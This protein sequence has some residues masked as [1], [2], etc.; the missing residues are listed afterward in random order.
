MDAGQGRSE[1]QDGA[2]TAPKDPES[3]V[4]QEFSALPEALKRVLSLENASQR[5]K[6]KFERRQAMKQHQLHPTDTGSPESQIAMLTVRINRG[7]QHIRS[8]RKDNPSKRALQKFVEARK[9]HLKYLK[10]ESEERYYALIKKLD[11][12]D[13]INLIP[14]RAFLPAEAQRAALDKELRKQQE[15]KKAAEEK[16]AAIALGEKM[17]AQHAARL[18][19]QRLQDE[20][21]QREREAAQAEVDKAAAA[22][23]G[24]GEGK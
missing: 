2:A 23:S 22:A 1:P 12:K 10:R 4:M 14:P 6:N 5:E 3:L 7:N 8:A 18:E 24:Q 20:A 17:R 16:A 13:S 15:R 11:L 19:Q 21:H 9:R